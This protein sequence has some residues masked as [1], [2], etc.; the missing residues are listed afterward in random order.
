MRGEL[1]AYERRNSILNFLR[2]NRESTRTELSRRYNV[3]LV[4]IQR[5]IC[6][7]TR[8]AP[9]VTKSGNGGGIFYIGDNSERVNLYLTLGEEECLNRALEM[10]SETDKMIIQNIIYKFSIPKMNKDT[11]TYIGIKLS[12]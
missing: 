9:I 8:I 7:L 11:G 3:S 6:F 4:T 5:D 2:C 1:T 10:V 12:G